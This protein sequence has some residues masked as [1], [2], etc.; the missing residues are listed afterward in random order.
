M[1]KGLARRGF[2]EETS[3]SRYSEW[4]W[5]MTESHSGV[6]S[7]AL[8]HKSASEEAKVMRRTGVEQQVELSSL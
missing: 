2:Q 3:C 7:L 4:L 1:S 5:T 6:F 8:M